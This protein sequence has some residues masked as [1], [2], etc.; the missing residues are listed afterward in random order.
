MVVIKCMLLNSHKILVMICLMIFN[1]K[2]TCNIS[3]NQMSLLKI[4]V[5]GYLVILLLSLEI[6]GNHCFLLIKTLFKVYVI[7][8]V[9]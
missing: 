3:S 8:V 7:L 1:F 9:L 6:Q 5:L 4:S 2:I